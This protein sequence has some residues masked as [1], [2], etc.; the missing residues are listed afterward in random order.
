M[1]FD[2]ILFDLDGT[3]WN[4]T[5]AIAK[6]WATVLQ[7]A[8]DV[9][10]CP[11][12]R[13][14]EGVMGMTAEDL[15]Q[16]LFPHLPLSRRLELFEQ[17]CDAECAYLRVHGGQLYPGV[18]QMLAQLSQKLPLAIVSNCNAEYIP[19]FL[20]GHQLWD[21]F[22]DWECIGR[23]GLQKGDNIRLVISRLG[24]KAPLYVGDTRMDKAAADSAGV[25]FLHA[26]YGFGRVPDCDSIAAPLELPDYLEKKGDRP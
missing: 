22:A 11:G 23:T 21:L 8:P 3:L 25:P 20:D 7:A 13:E 4:A 1:G 2:G 9:P 19:A 18:P 16:T 6:S 10:R 17:C 14:L 5:Q 12:I 15:T 26:A 24:L